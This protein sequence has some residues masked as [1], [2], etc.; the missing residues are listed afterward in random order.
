[1]LELAKI[2]SKGMILQREKETA[3]WGKADSH[4]AVS[5]SIQGVTGNTTANG[6][7]VW[8]VKLAP[9]QASAMET[10]IVKS[11][12]ETIVV[13]EVAV[14]EVWI[15][16]GQSNMEFSLRYEKHSTEELNQ[17][18][19][20]LRFYDV[21][22][23]FYEEQDQDFD[24]SNVGFWRKAEGDSLSYFSAVGYYFQKELEEKLNVPV[25]IVSCNWGGTRSCA[26]MREETVKKKGMPWMKEWENAT[27]GMDMAEYWAELRTN[28]RSN[29][30]NPNMDPFSTFVLPQT[31]TM[32]EIAAFFRKML[33][34]EEGQDDD[35]NVEELMGPE[36]AV[37]A[38]IKP[39][40]LYENMV[41]KTAPYTVRGIIWYQGESDDVPG[42]QSLYAD[43]MEGLICDW[44]EAWG[45]SFLPFLQ[46]QLPGWSTW[47]M[48]KNLDY[49]A[50]RRCQEE[51]TD[52]MEGVYMASISDVGEE[53]DIHPKDKKT[54]GH[55]LA[56]L[57]RHYVYGEELLCEAPRPEKIRREGKQ[58]AITFLHTGVGLKLAG[59]CVEA[60]SVSIDGT[61]IAHTAK[62]QGDELIIM[63]EKDEQKPVKVN[64]A[65]GA[66]YL[67]NLYNEADIPAV[68]FTLVC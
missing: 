39:G 27:A 24:Y 62:V 58:I 3:V 63:L 34:H 38:R 56:L 19:P 36:M 18:N 46:V 59:E 65:Q 64:F 10:M 9:L 52:R 1:M 61:E 49:T 54:V 17:M 47:L 25:G 67:V 30:G 20:N 43:M 11:E 35:I 21:P 57:A 29:A 44:R 23:K 60:L 6:G 41:V 26:W 4:A 12:D 13:E 53:M 31:P 45:D 51:V 28:P 8:M 14:G 50:I 48:Q 7:G 15:A 32:E 22:E 37:D 33:K 55:R 68:P 66:W 42:L 2:F 40:I 5:V 16:G